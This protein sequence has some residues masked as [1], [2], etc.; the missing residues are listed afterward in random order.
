MVL[1]DFGSFWSCSYDFGR[2]L[3]VFAR[4]R[5]VR[6]TGERAHGRANPARAQAS[7]NRSRIQRKQFGTRMNR[8]KRSL[9]Y[10][11][12]PHIRFSL[13]RGRVPLDLRF[14]GPLEAKY[15]VR[16]PKIDPPGAP[17]RVFDLNVDLVVVTAA[18]RA[19]MQKRFRSGQGS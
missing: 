19:L 16:S 6:G 8:R 18:V 14:R 10:S 12:G 9:R 2:F 11:G 13:F 1:V 15:F 3:M 4:F 7:R 5:P 17:G